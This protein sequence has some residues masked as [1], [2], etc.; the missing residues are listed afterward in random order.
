[1]TRQ[2]ALDLLADEDYEPETYEEAAEIFA[3]LYE[4]HPDDEDGDLG[5]IWS[6]CCAF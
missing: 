5:Q 4:R 6:L 1:V 2:E 3:A